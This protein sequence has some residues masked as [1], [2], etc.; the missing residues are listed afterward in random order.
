VIIS[1]LWSLLISCLALAVSIS[2]FYFQHLRRTRRAFAS[3]LWCQRDG[4]RV[5]FEA[6]IS[7]Q[8]NRPITVSRIWLLSPP[9]GNYRVRYEC[10]SINQTAPLK[11]QPMSGEFLRLPF[12]SPENIRLHGLYPSMQPAAM[13]YDLLFYVTDDRGV[14]HYSSVPAVKLAENG[15]GVE[16]LRNSVRIVPGTKSSEDSRHAGQAA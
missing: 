10:E 13:T 12:P 6:S 2:G 11:V 9:K 16:G 8:G 7:N 3:I 15:G 4:E 1:P 14:E 5:V